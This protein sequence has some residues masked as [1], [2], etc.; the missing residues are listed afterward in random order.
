[1]D[2]DYTTVLKNFMDTEG[3][4]TL[5]PSKRKMKSYVLLYMRY[6]TIL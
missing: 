2:I 4:I 3:R 1:M 6:M 5:F